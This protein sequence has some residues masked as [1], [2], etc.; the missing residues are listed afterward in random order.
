M[1][2]PD[3]LAAPGKAT[4]TAANVDRMA[5]AMA[6]HLG[7]AF[8]RAFDSRPAQ[9]QCLGA[10][11]KFR[12]ADMPSKDDYRAAVRAV[13]EAKW[14]AAALREPSATLLRPLPKKVRLPL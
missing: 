1:T 10:D 11:G 13:W 6:V 5:R 8:D 9:R 4:L 14:N 2:A 7:D 12:G 3:P